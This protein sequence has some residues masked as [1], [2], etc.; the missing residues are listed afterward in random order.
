MELGRRVPDHRESK[1]WLAQR[2]DNGRTLTASGPDGLRELMI[3]DY[4]AAVAGSREGS[5]VTAP[6][7]ARPGRRA[8][9]RVPAVRGQ[10]GHLAG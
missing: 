7:R 3:E 8:A 4:A 6:V 9:H 2:R 5:A 10:S 1:H